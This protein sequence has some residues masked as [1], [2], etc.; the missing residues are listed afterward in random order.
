MVVSQVDVFLMMKENRCH[1]GEIT[2]EGSMS[3]LRCTVFFVGHKSTPFQT[4]RST[5][6]YKLIGGMPML[7]YLDLKDPA[8]F[9]VSQGN[10]TWCLG[11]LSVGWVRLR[12][13]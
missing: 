1:N 6:S 11:F 4:K 2:G 12:I 13:R 3:N 7:N 9:F 8:I 5:M 10:L